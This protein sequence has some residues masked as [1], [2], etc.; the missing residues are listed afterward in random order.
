MNELNRK[1]GW[2]KQPHDVRDLGFKF[3]SHKENIQSGSLPISVN[4]RFWCSSVSDQGNLGSCTANAWAN[5]LEY[6]E[7]A[8]GRG[9]KLYKDLSR[10]FVYYNERVA[11]N[12]PVDQDAGAMLRTGAKVIAKY[13][14]CIEKEWPY[15]IN[16]FSQKPTTKSYTDALP[17]IITNYYALTTLNDMKTCLAN[18][19]CFV[20]GFYVFDYFESNQMANTGVL[21]LPKSN[22]SLLG[23][24]AVMAMGYDDTQKRFLLKNS[25]GRN[26]GLKGNL[27]GY[28]TMPYDYIT[29]P[30]LA[31][32]FWTVV[33]DV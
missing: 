28:F 4:N 11:E 16:K 17:N 22:E 6:N 23:G 20:F 13:G 31:T 8:A 2:K 1:Y 12:T 30:N 7:C 33:R 3:L 19:Q 10:L 15:I 26:W 5:I 29:N 25:W 18:Q 32:D 9:G 24:H 21:Y 27:R 14:V